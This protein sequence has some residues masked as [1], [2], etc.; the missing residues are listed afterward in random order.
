MPTVRCFQMRLSVR[1][2]FECIDVFWETFA[3]GVD[4]VEHGA[5]AG[6]VKLLQYFGVAEFAASYLGMKSGRSR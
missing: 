2:G 4:K 5:F 1:E 6:F 3:E